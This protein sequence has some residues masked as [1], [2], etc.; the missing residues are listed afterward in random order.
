M[1]VAGAER[2]RA[3]AAVPTV[4]ASLVLDVFAGFVLDTSGG[5]VFGH[6]TTQQTADT[7]VHADQTV[8]RE[9]IEQYEMVLKAGAAA[10]ELALN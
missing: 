6:P 8:R 2:R 3:R 4:N 1:G 5:N 9:W 7:Y 10:E